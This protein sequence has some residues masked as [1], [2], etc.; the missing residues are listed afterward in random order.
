VGPQRLQGCPIRRMPEGALGRQGARGPDGSSERTPDLQIRAGPVG[1]GVATS[2]C[3]PLAGVYAPLS[4][5]LASG[6]VGYRL[7]CIPAPPNPPIPC[8]RVGQPRLAHL[9]PQLKARLLFVELECQHV[10]PVPICPVCEQPMTAGGKLKQLFEL[11]D[12][13]SYQCRRCAVMTSVS[14]EQA[15]YDGAASRIARLASFPSREER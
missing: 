6:P 15:D 10:S 12:R 1:G 9:L 11:P 7:Y 5:H 13:R 14:V 8:G 2:R 4:I 3:C